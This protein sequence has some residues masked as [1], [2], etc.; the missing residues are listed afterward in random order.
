MDHQ[1]STQRQKVKF[2]EDQVLNATSIL[3]YLKQQRKKEVELLQE[4]CNHESYIAE[5]NGDCHSGGYYYTC[6]EC[7]KFQM[8]KPKTGSIIWK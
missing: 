4:I 7:G 8:I 1:L 3:S 5:S 6:K 2:L